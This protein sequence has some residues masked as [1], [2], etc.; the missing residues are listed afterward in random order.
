VLSG[1]NPNFEQ[2]KTIHGQGLR[3]GVQNILK[4]SIFI[5][6][7]NKSFF[8]GGEGVLYYRRNKDFYGGGRGEMIFGKS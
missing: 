3:S 4:I 1:K 2:Y 5:C 7:Q 8:S 6:K